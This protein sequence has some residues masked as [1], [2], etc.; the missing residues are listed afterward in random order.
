M[1]ANNNMP[2]ISLIHDDENLSMLDEEDADILREKSFH[3]KFIIQ[4]N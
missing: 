3:K 1:E 2:H 4:G